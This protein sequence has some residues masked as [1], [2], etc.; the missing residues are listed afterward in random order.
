MKILKMDQN[1]FY[2]IVQVLDSTGFCNVKN[3]TSNHFLC[4]TSEWNNEKNQEIN[5]W[6]VQL[7]VFLTNPSLHTWTC[8]NLIYSLWYFGWYGSN[9]QQDPLSICQ[10]SNILIK[11]SI[12]I[13][14]KSNFEQ[15]SNWNSL[16]SNSLKIW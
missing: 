12:P 1:W 8:K 2:L 10:T 9:L 11:L 3:H 14:L 16:K 4:M 7:T 13:F 15:L 6:T 5:K